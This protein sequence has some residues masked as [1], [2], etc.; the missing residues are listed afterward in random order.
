[1]SECDPFVFF[2]TGSPL[3]PSP[4]NRLRLYPSCPSETHVQPIPGF[5]TCAHR[6]REH[7]SSLASTI[8]CAVILASCPLAR[9][10]LIPAVRTRLA[11]VAAEFLNVAPNANDDARMG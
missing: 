7:A 11:S 4:P 6:L 9:D 10:L 1:M 5:R 3:T 8:A 2:L